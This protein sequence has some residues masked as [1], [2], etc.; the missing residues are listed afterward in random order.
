MIKIINQ[1]DK[2]ISQQHEIQKYDINFNQEINDIVKEIDES[3]EAKIITKQ[4]G[5][6]NVSQKW[7]YKNSAI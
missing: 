2:A 7:Q 4:I 3:D 5:P 1:E 6:K